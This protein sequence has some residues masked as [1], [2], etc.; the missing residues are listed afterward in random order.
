MGSAVCRCNRTGDKEDTKAAWTVTENFFEDMETGLGFME[1]GDF[2]EV[3]KREL[4]S[5]HGTLEQAGGD[6]R[7]RHTG[8]AGGRKLRKEEVYL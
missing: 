8:Q 5:G 3:K 7:T 1:V 2:R 6:I 4:A